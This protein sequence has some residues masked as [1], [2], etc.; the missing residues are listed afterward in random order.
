MS[1]TD[2][3]TTLALYMGRDQLAAVS[4]ELTAQGRSPATPAIAKPPPI[5]IVTRS[6]MRATAQPAGML[7]QSCPTTRAEATSAAVGTS[8]PRREAKIGRSG[9]TAPSPSANRTVGP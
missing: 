7:P 3:E 5:A 1:R 8:A 2:P 9:M 4:A 6:P